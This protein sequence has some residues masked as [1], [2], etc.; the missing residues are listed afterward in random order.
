MSLSVMIVEGHRGVR[1]GLAQ[2]LGHRSGEVGAVVAVDTLE[3][4]RRGM[5]D[6]APD[7]VL[8]DP[9]TLAGGA[10]EVVR[11]LGSTGVPIV[12]LTSSLRDGE[13]DAL[14]RAGARTVLLKGLAVTVLLGEIEMALAQG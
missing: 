2:R 1:E 3:A 4:A 10:E 11:Q 13:E 14:R 12:V 8:C 9:R 6:G 7:V 5:Q